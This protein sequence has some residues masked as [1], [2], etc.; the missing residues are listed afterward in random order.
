MTEKFNFNGFF[1]L[2]KRAQ[3]SILNELMSSN[4]TYIFYESKHRIIKSLECIN[5]ILPDYK[6]VV[7][8]ELTKFFE[9]FFEGTAFEI[10][11]QFKNSISLVKGE[12]VILIE[13]KSTSNLY[14]SLVSIED[15][16]PLL[17][18][19]LSTKDITCIVSQLLNCDKQ[20]L[21]SRILSLKK[22][23][24]IP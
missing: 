16:L 10:I 13:G 6:I 18:Q 21:Y 1:P 14:S 12:F 24:T 11:N 2:K 19:Y 20:D 17:I 7:T 5:R 23:H 4:K 3:E 9:E 22:E 15:I 8:K